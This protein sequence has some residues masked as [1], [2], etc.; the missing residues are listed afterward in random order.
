MST[1]QTNRKN[2]RFAQLARSGE[3]VFHARDLANLWGITS[4]N[5]LYTTLKRYTQSGML[6]RIYKGFYSLHP[7]R[8]IDPYLL[9][10]KAL[11]QYAYVSTETILSHEGII[12]QPVH[13]ITFVSAQSKHLIIGQRQYRSRKLRDVF[14]FN[15]AGVIEKDGV[16]F[17][18]LERAVADMLYFNPR[19]HFDAETRIDWKKVRRVQQQVGYPSSVKSI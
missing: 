12:N 6:F 11:H 9:G 3:T 7:L 13:T 8:E 17:A 14:L 10:A 2:D 18:S 15:N 19:F 5:T 4:A 1:E 16:L